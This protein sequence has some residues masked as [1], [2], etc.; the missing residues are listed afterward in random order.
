MEWQRNGQTLTSDG[1]VVSEPNAMSATV[2]AR[3]TW[4]REFLDSDAGSYQC[5]VRKPNTDIAVT[6]QTV[7][8][9]AGTSSTTE[10]P[11]SCSVQE[12][13]VYFQI[14]VL[15]TDCENWDEAQKANTASEFRDELL[16]VV[17]TECGCE[18]DGSDLQVS[19]SPQ[20][21]SKV[22]R[23]AVFRGQVQT[24]SQ[25][26]TQQ[27]FCSLFVWQQRSPL[28]RIGDLLRAVDNS[29]SLEAS[30]SPNSEECVAPEAPPQPLIGVMEIIIIAV[31]GV[32]LILVLVVL[33]CCVLCYCCYRLKRKGHF[34][35]E[36]SDRNE[37][38]HTYA[39]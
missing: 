22:D 19:E 1:G 9:K 15:G 28:I 39:R 24:G 36:T 10:P 35:V 17:R 2:L 3:L 8:L 20:C 29:C 31:G 12:Q 5:V 30:S 37:D 6:S 34:D 7:Q 23:A 32:I 21:S 26:N 27:I 14:R 33:I 11:L 16:S 38:D 18:V 4:T 13:S 25:A